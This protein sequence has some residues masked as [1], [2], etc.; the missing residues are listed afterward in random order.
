MIN[1]NIHP[2]LYLY[3]VWTALGQVIRH[4]YVSFNSWA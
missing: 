1:K 3:T 2:V 4:L